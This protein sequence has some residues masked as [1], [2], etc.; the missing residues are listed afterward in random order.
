MEHEQAPPPEDMMEK[1]P[2]HQKLCPP[3]HNGIGTEEDSLGNCNALQPKQPKIDLGKLMTLE[4]EQL[5]LEAKMVNGEPEDECRRF[6]ITF[7]PDT[8]RIGVHETATRN[9]GHMAGRFLEMSKTKNPA[10]GKL[11]TPAD[12]YVG[13]TVLISAQPFQIIRADEHCL[14]YP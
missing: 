2:R 8:D 3:P 5:R 6:I 14:Q 10:T 11:F 9:S 4:G 12:L 13:A 7:L 1:A